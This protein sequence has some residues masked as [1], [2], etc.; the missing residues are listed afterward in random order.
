M[1]EKE[2][3]GV[4]AVNYGTA[5]VNG[6][7]VGTTEQDLRLYLDQAL[8]APLRSS[9][10]E[11]H[12][13][14]NKK[15]CQARLK[16]QPDA[17][18]SLKNELKGRRFRGCKFSDFRE[19]SEIASMAA[20][21]RKNKARRR[22]KAEKAR[23]NAEKS[24][25]EG[26]ISGLPINT[27]EDDLSLYLDLALPASLRPAI[28]GIH[29]R[30]HKKTCSG[31]LELQQ[32]KLDALQDALKGRQFKGRNFG[33]QKLEERLKQQQRAKKKKKR[34]TKKPKAG[35]VEARVFDEETKALAEGF[36]QFLLERPEMLEQASD[37]DAMGGIFRD[38]YYPVKTGKS[39][40]PP[41]S[42]EGHI[43]AVLRVQGLVTSKR[44]GNIYIYNSMITT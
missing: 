6:M 13:K 39:D 7:M 28:V 17:V 20:R 8:P 31:R 22:R 12:F 38:C 32:E 9:I 15:S 2:N 44:Y 16:L 34:K 29:L 1:E 30:Q 42:L 24:K 23:R 25:V 19:P 43:L 41:D 26:C 4:E 36:H 10:Q 3:E 33:F 5:S 21:A 11:I 18:K 27:T 37:R 40:P 14:Q 35:G